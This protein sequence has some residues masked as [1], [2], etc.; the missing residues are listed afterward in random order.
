MAKPT[1]PS[2][3][4]GTEPH[5]NKKGGLAAA[6]SR[7]EDPLDYAAARLTPLSAIVVNL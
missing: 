6:P 2:L 1:K 5:A 4:A 3:A 7:A